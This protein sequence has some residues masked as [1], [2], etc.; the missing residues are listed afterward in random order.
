MAF[1]FLSVCL[2]LVACPGLAQ[3]APVPEAPIAAAPVAPRTAG[4]VAEPMART[5]PAEIQ[6]PGSVGPPYVNLELFHQ[7]DYF[8]DTDDRVLKRDPSVQAKAQ[9]GATFQ[10]GTL[11]VYGTVGVIKLPGTQKMVQRR[12]EVEIDFYG[13]RRSEG[14]VVIYNR[15]ELPFSD[16]DFD[17]DNARPSR[18]GTIYTLGGTPHVQ[19]V[20]DLGGVHLL[21]SLTLDAWSS[22]FSRRQFV[23]RDDMA[24]EKDE[25]F[26]LA[27]EEQGQPVEATAPPVHNEITAGVGIYPLIWR[28]LVLE[29]SVVSSHDHEPVY[30]LDQDDRISHKYNTQR[31][32]HYRVSLTLQVNKSVSISNDFYHYHDGFFEERIKGTEDG[33]FRNT[34]KVSCRL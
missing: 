24:R 5:A 17:K 16:A 10:R 15:V 8:Y 13:L 1:R 28:G 2:L 21:V 7:S 32:S 30:F 34:F 29:T 18:Q 3:M 31:T 27:Q 9:I 33:R 26:F 12:P 6:G 23:S 14:S 22:F 20:S 11:D 4:A 19:H 25:S